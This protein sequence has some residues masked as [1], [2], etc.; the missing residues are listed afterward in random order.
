[1]SRPYFDITLVTCRSFASK[2]KCRNRNLSVEMEYGG[3]S[4]LRCSVKKQHRSCTLILL[5]STSNALLHYQF[6]SYK[7]RQLYFFG[8]LKNYKK[9]EIGSVRVQFFYGLALH[10]E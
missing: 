9:K 10:F 3:V 2:R 6:Y 8:N 5:S 7:T 4:Y 1:M